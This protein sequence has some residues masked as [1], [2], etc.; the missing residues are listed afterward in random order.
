MTDRRFA[1]LL[2]LVTLLATGLR[3]YR[4]GEPSLWSDEMFQV[5]DSLAISNAGYLPTWLGMWLSGV[6][7]A[8]LDPERM[9]E[10]RAAG[11]EPV[12]MRLGSALVGGQTRSRFMGLI[13]RCTMP[14]C[15]A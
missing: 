13:S 7:T 15:Q 9:G 10:W 1:M 14:D 3:L 11:L 5:S 12:H 4:L 6:P 2:L 8:E